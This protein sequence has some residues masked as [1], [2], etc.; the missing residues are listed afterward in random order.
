VID[1]GGKKWFSFIVGLD[2]SSKGAGPW[3]MA[4]G[5]P[6]PGPGD[7]IVPRVFADMTGLQLG[8][9]VAI[10]DRKFRIS[11]FS[12]DTFSMGNTVIFVTKPDLE[13]VMSSLDIVS[14]MLVKANPGVSPDML[15]RRIE[16][17]VTKVSALPSHAFVAND[18]SMVMQ[19]GVETI[20]LMTTIG[21][22]L[23]ILLV[24]FTVYSQI[25]RQQ[26]ELAVAKALG[27]TNRMLLM[28]VTAQATAISVISVLVALLLALVLVPLTD[29]LV[30]QVTLRITG[31]AIE[32]IAVLGVAVALVASLVPARRIAR[33]DPVTAFHS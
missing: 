4:E 11:G 14:F 24:A 16:S 13:D 8:D 7:A 6:M 33:A 15:A 10:T 17:N 3:S 5:K 31:S 23:A 18:R 28:S 9:I 25:A 2:S 19:M 26:R 30:P 29:A 20:A 32:R 12:A 1:A 21:G 27:A 22:S